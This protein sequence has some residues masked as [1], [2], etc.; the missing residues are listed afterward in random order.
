MFNALS[1]V[2]GVT[3][4]KKEDKIVLVV[5]LVVVMLMVIMVEGHGGPRWRGQHGSI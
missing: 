5:L 1:T 2:K 4:T 3:N